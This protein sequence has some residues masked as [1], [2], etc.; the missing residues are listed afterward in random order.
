MSQTLSFSALHKFPESFMR[1]Q[2]AAQPRSRSDN[3]TS[4]PRRRPVS[5]QRESVITFHLPE[6][7][8]SAC[9]TEAKQNSSAQCGTCGQSTGMLSLHLCGWTF[10]KYATLQI[11][12]KNIYIYIYETSDNSCFNSSI[13]S[14]SKT[15]T[16]LLNML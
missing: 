2:L 8:F 11:Q 10:I 16:A 14:E 1:L 15:L 13:S 6:R 12:N 9:H 4:T 7:M 3:K 5:Y